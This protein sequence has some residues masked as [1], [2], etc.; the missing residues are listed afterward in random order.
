MPW[1]VASEHPAEW[2]IGARRCWRPSKRSGRWRLRLPGEVPPGCFY[3][4]RRESHDALAETGISLA[5]DAATSLAFRVRGECQDDGLRVGRR[6]EGHGG[7]SA[8]PH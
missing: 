5:L 2:R 1:R 3:R 6:G 8:I 7:D 4:G